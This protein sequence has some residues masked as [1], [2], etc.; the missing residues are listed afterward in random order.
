[1]KCWVFDLDGT[2]VDSF[3]HYFVILTDIFNSNGAKFREE[4]RLPALTQKLPEFFEQH[5]G[6]PAVSQAMIT[7]QERSNRDASQVRPF[8]GVI[9][10]IQKLRE[11]GDRVAVWTNRDL[12]SAQL[13]IQHSGLKPFV[14]ICISG[15]CTVERKPFPEGLLRIIN[16]FGC[17]ADDVTMIGDHEHDVTAAK[18]VGTRAI[19]ASWHSYW[20]FEPCTIADYQF[21][22]FEDFSRWVDSQSS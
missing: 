1:M 19:R 17:R 20:Q 14:E 12:Q 9:E 22:K 16:H 10:L 11:R 7:L 13:I 18:S 3:E 2:L 15:T 5:L 8:D 4:L 21:H 6:K